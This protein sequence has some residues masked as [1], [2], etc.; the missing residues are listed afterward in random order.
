MLYIQDTFHYTAV[1]PSTIS[2]VCAIHFAES[3]TYYA[4]KGIKSILPDCRA[5]KMLHMLYDPST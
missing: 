1:A 4:S 5:L 2:L 3:I